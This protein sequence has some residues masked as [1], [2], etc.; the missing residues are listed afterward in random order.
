[1][2]RRIIITIFIFCLYRYSLAE[3]LINDFHSDII[4]KVDRSLEV[5][6]TIRVVVE[7]IKIKEGIYRDIPVEMITPQGIKTRAPLTVS[8]VLL[9]GNP[10]NYEVRNHGRFERIRIGTKGVLLEHGTHIFT[11]VYDIG[12]QVKLS[13][14]FDAFHW[15][16]TGSE[17]GVTIQNASVR[18][19]LPAGAKFLQTSSLSGYPGDSACNCTVGPAG[20]ST[21]EGYMTGP[22]YPSMSYT[23]SASFTKG[24]ILPQSPDEV[25]A[26]IFSRKRIF[27]AGL[28]G[29]VLSILTYFIA[30][31]IAGR[32]RLKSG[33]VFPKFSPPEGMPADVCRVFFK[34][35]Y[36]KKVFTAAIVQLAVKGALLIKRDESSFTLVKSELQPGNLSLTESGIMEKLFSNSASLKVSSYNFKPL[37]EALRFHEMKTYR[38]YGTINFHLSRKWIYPGI[39][40]SLAT[41]VWMNLW[42][43]SYN[44]DTFNASIIIDSG[45]ILIIPFIMLLIMKLHFN[46]NAV[47]VLFFAALMLSIYFLSG[48]LIK[49][50]NSSYLE[51]FADQTVLLFYTGIL[52][53]MIFTGLLFSRTIIPKQFRNKS[54]L[55][56][57]EGLKLY[58]REIEQNKSLVKNY[59]D[60]TARHFEN[61][62]PYAIALDAERIWTGKFEKILTMTSASGYPVVSW[63]SG[64]EKEFKGT[65]F[66][67]DISTT[68]NSALASSYFPLNKPNNDYEKSLITANGVIHS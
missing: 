51:T 37:F 50:F 22:L 2:L 63:Y 29:L 54:L 53:F 40:I 39:I 64:S 17:S 56:H 42:I 5:R 61:L 13:D 55:D 48:F 46:G 44:K 20:K 36:D 25:Q 45:F 7:G 4:V 32:E 23:V 52:M 34:S 68:L 47:R 21:W 18:I 27:F 33:M 26:L 41:L 9:D 28:S 16:I 59:P 14:D 11:L 15:N 67:E 60:M 58:L 3:E 43:Y 57:L 10:E 19:L 35:G 62:L 30:F 8:R 38:K 65:Q 49:I 31:Y 12:N 1:M 6:E 66:I 24:F